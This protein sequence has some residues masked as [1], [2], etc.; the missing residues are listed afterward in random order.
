[1]SRGNPLGGFPFSATLILGSPL[2][3]TKATAEVLD[4]PLRSVFSLPAA[5]VGGLLV[6]GGVA[7]ARWG[8][9]DGSL[10]LGNGP[11]AVG[12]AFQVHASVA[13]VRFGFLK[14][15]GERGGHST[16]VLLFFT[17]IMPIVFT[18]G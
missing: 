14:G 3:P 6:Q 8:V 16:L 15:R 10:S 17:T 2:G 9:H 5:G 4:S 13:R 18:F 11:G 1:M 7:S 12:V